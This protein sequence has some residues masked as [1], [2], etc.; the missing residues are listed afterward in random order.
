MCVTGSSLMVILD[1][2]KRIS[3]IASAVFAA[4][5]TIVGGFYSV[6]YT[7]VLQQLLITIGL[8]GVTRN[9]DYKNSSYEF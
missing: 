5:Y 4:A 1:L 9:E 7:D 8:V 3:V 2:D 6:S